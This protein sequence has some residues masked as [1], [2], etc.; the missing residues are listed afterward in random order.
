[1]LSR[2]YEKARRLTMQ[3]AASVR[4]TKRLLKAAHA[5]LV[6]TTMAEE[7]RHFKARLSS[8]EASEA[9]AAFLEKRKPDF[10]RFV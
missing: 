8:P 4:L 5:D 3:P 9:F 1:V 2:A 7:A 10:S 6:K